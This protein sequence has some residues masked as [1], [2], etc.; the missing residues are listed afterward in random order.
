MKRIVSSKIYL[1]CED[2]LGK[3][4]VQNEINLFDAFNKNN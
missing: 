4:S 1:N 3:R 2:I